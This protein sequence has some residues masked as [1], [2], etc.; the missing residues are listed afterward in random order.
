MAGVR[1]RSLSAVIQ[2]DSQMENFSSENIMTYCLSMKDEKFQVTT[3]NFILDLFKQYKKEDNVPPLQ[4][5]C[6]RYM[7]KI[8]KSIRRKRKKGN[9]Q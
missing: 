1:E 5:L 3:A 6:L 7:G 4:I 8:R 9:V 2:L